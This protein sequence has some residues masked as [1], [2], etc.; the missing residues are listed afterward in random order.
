M[1]RQQPS[2]ICGDAKHGGVADDILEGRSSRSALARL[3][4][5]CVVDS[6]VEGST[7]QWCDTVLPAFLATAE[8]QEGA[9][10]ARGSRVD[11]AGRTARVLVVD[12]DPEFQEVIGDVLRE[13]G[14]EPIAA[15]GGVEGIE[16]L[17]A[18]PDIDAMLLD[19]MMPGL[20]GYEVCK[21]I[22][23]SSSTSLPIIFVSAKAQTEDVQR[24]LAAGGDDYIA[25]PFD[26]RRL[27]EA[28][29]RLLE[30]PGE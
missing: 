20:D 28:L 15:Y 11:R 24:G 26:M 22:K 12:D 14:F 30:E 6:S 23:Q 8:S 21:K 19:V 7:P 1:Q 9:E 10:Q 16:A 3:G 17:S 25:K 18:D 27:V 29:R 13:N 5:V 4:E 2:V